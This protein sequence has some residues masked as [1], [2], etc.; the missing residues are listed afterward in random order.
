[1][2]RYAGNEEAG[3]RISAA[4]HMI[5]NTTGFE[6]PASVAKPGEDRSATG[7]QASGCAGCHYQPWFAL[8]SVYVGRAEHARLALSRRAR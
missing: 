3:I 5:Q 7:R 1:M 6:V 2:L 4:Y 8:D